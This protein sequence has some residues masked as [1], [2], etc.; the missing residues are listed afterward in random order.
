MRLGLHVNNV[1]Q[2]GSRNRHLFDHYVATVRPEVC[3]FLADAY[4]P[5]VVDY[6]H[7]LGVKVIGRRVQNM[8][9]LGPDGRRAL[10]S[11]RAWGRASGWTM[12]YLEAANE[13]W[14]SE[15]E[16]WDRL[17]DYMYDFMRSLDDETGGRVKG[18]IY[19][20]SVGAPQF[21]FWERDRCLRA[22]EYAGRNGHVVGLHSYF[23]PRPWY[24][25]QGD[26]NLWGKVW[27]WWLLREI[28]VAQI[29]EANLST[30][31]G[32]I[33][34]E[35][36]RDDISGTPGSGKGYR[37]E[38]RG[39]GM[40]YADWTRDYLHHL[41]Y[42]RLARGCVDFGFAST[43]ERWDSFNM[44]LDIAMLARQE[45]E[46]TRLPRGV[47]VQPMPG[48]TQTYHQ[49]Q[50]GETLSR[51]GVNYGI[52]WKL[53]AAANNLV[54]PYL[55][56]V[57][58][59]LRIPVSGNVS[60]PAK[61][62]TI[63]D[64]PHTIKR[65]IGTDQKSWIV[66]HDPGVSASFDAT[67]SALLTTREKVSYNE[68]FGK[69]DGYSKSVARLLVPASDTAWHAGAR[70]RIPGT[71]V[72][73]SAVNR[74]TYGIAHVYPLSEDAYLPLVWRIVDLIRQFN[75]PDAG[76]VLGHREVATLRTDP[77]LPGGRSM[78]DLRRD[79]HNRLV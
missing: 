31:P 25:V 56:R 21:E 34:T 71:N 72:V 15:P 19:N 65:D 12:D 30:P 67:V 44:A 33:I 59:M 53:I 60:N 16:Y 38:P 7:S 70:S 51:I 66:V 3:K 14:T 58:D 29:W 13:E 4:R 28:R 37:D 6:C 45:S 76:V 48:Q 26:W 68:L 64:G 42:C 40:D 74:R 24:G 54:H 62:Y 55:L 46:Q 61:Q 41:T 17:S 2:A 35:Y 22:L 52:P 77:R 36:G 69:P 8:P 43:E 10:D 11:V 49:V 78:T 20:S 50:R 5:D 57:G 73:L 18:C 47:I 63:V 32:F 79:I 27:G 1:L 39:D 23:K 75:M 9:S